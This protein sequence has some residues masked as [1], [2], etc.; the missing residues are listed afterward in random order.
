M[1]LRNVGFCLFI[2]LSAEPLR[3]LLISQLKSPTIKSKG[4][5]RLIWFLLLLLRR[6]PGR[7]LG[8]PATGSIRLTRTGFTRFIRAGFIWFDTG[9]VRGTV[10]SYASFTWW[11]T[12]FYTWFIWRMKLLG[13]VWR[14]YIR[15]KRIRKY[16]WTTL[17]N[18]LLTWWL[19]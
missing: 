8:A 10:R 2:V 1:G 19:W 18:E 3:F 17:C 4:Y 6:P 11:T 15:T 16:L 13:F 14:I 12:R 7:P 9:F 5:M